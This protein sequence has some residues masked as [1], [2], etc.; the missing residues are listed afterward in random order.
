MGFDDKDIAIIGIV[1]IFIVSLI[2]LAVMP[3]DLA[4]KI[5]DKLATVW[6]S[7][8]GGLAGMATGRR[9]SD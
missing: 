2:A 5:A 3:H 4:V 9:R 7:L 6:G 8:A 1:L